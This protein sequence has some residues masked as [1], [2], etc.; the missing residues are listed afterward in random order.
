MGV[1]IVCFSRVG[2]G[3][4]ILGEIDDKI[5]GFIISDNLNF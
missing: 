4:I 2:S 1:V 3:E 5:Y